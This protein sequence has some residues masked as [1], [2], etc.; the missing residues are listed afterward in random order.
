MERRSRLVR[1]A[2]SGHEIMILPVFL[3][4]CGYRESVCRKTFHC[5]LFHKYHREGRSLLEAYRSSTLLS[6]INF[7]LGTQP[8][9]ANTKGFLLQA[10]PSQHG[11][12][13]QRPRADDHCGHHCSAWSGSMGTSA[14]LSAAN[15]GAKNHVIDSGDGL[16][17]ANNSLGAGGAL[18]PYLVCL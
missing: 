6:A 17:N 13:A 3:L 14:I 7:G 9:L 11:F 1:I 18:E 4:G 12:P 10:S 8:S 15:L 2:P 16:Q 5:R